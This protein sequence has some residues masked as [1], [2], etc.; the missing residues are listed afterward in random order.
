MLCKWLHWWD[1]QCAERYHAMFPHTGATHRTQEPR[2]VGREAEAST[3]YPGCHVYFTRFISWEV[4]SRLWLRVRNGSLPRLLLSSFMLRKQKMQSNFELMGLLHSLFTQGGALSQRLLS[5]WQR[6]H[7]I[8]AWEVMGW[9]DGC[10]F[11]LFLERNA[12][13]SVS[14]AAV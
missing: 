9:P 6:R 14:V 11:R 3:W 5:V 13:V 10:C 8:S 1:P 7:L 4:E 2:L 12:S